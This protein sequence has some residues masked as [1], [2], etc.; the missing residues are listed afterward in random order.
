MKLWGFTFL[1]TFLF[2]QTGSGQSMI[3]M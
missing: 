2:H 3:N 1:E